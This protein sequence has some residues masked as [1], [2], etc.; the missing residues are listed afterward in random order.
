M[1]RGVPY[2]YNSA[3]KTSTW[4]PPAGLTTEALMN[5]PGAGQYL[6]G[7]KEPPQV[8]A[9]HLLVK[10]SGSRRPAS[11]KDV[12]PFPIAPPSLPQLHPNYQP[13][14][15]RSKEDAIA[16]LRGYQGE[17]AGDPAK[18]AQLAQEHS[19]CSSHAQ[20]GDLG[21]FKRGAMQKPFEDA[22]YALPVG[23]ISD[24]ISTDSGV[25]LI[26]RTA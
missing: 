6:S 5:L 9:S 8:R 17:I 3:T 2:Y 13:N 19:D 25:H 23:T 10:H 11:W 21:W 12:R 24:V 1:S 22:T 26:M 7:D 14:I 20:G 16:I 15:T 4:E 18:F